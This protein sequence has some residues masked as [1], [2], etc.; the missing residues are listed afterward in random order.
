L[1]SKIIITNNQ[2]WIVLTILF[3]LSAYDG[4]VFAQ[5]ESGGASVESATWRFEYDNDII[6]NKDNKISCGWSLQKHSAVAG[7]WEILAD[8]PGFVRYMGKAI[9]T[10]AAEG[11]VYRA[12]IAIGQVMQTPDD[13]SRS[14]LIK[15]DVPYA[16]VLTLQ[17]IW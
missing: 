5:A 16:G 8:V 13:L 9:P 15:D 17:A 12:G 6:F 10:L 1:S 14:D 2:R 4:N 3:L 7:S 11:L